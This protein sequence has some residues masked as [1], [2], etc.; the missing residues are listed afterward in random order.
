[1]R[2]GGRRSRPAPARSRPCRRAGS[3]RRAGAPA[4]AA[5]RSASPS[6]VGVAALPAVG[7]DHDDGAR[8]PPRAG[9]SGRRTPPAPRRAGC[10]RTSP[11]WRRPAA[12][13][14]R[15]GSRRRSSR[16]TRV[17]RVPRVNTSVDAGAAPHDDVGEAQQ[18]VGVGLHRAGH[19][20]QQHDLARAPRPVAAGAARPA[21]RRCAAP[22]AG[23]AGGPRRR[24]GR[25]ARRRDGRVGGSG[26]SSASRRPQVLALGRATA[27]RGRGG[28]APRRP[29]RSPAPADR[30]RRPVGA[31]RRPGGQHRRQARGPRA[32]AAPCGGR[33]GSASN[34]STNARS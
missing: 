28:A 26:R 16:V 24:G 2:Q 22:R 11:G 10:R 14:A 9:P 17:S 1:M 29:R 15:S 23:C 20:D 19:V 18:R 31:V 21:R 34:Q 30:R 33:R 12:A 7:E 25:G 6:S 8:G 5:A 27:R 3:P 32:A 13:S 4:G